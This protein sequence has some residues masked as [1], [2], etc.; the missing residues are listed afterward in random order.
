MADYEVL[1]D[2]DPDQLTAVAAE[3]YRLWLAFAL[4]AAT[5]G[6]QTLA[7][8]SG[9]YAASISWHRTGKAS[10]AIIADP[11]KAKEAD[12]IEDGAPAHNRREAM[13]DGGGFV[14][15]SKSGS[16]YRF[17]PIR[18]DGTVPPASATD[19]IVSSPGGERLPAGIARVWGHRLSKNPDHYATM[20]SAQDADA[21]E[22]PA[23]PAMAPAAALAELLQ[24]Q[25][26]GRA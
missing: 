26:G 21:W 1:T 23:M 8:P 24:R 12:Y 15:I 6:G 20:S 14:H 3:T 9:R 7:H 17:I 10:V 18:K 5:V 13:L 4:G 22:V 16:R 11:G 25:Y 19:D 2:L